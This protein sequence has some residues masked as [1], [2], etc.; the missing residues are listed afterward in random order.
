MSK[1][2]L[3][4][5]NQMIQQSSSEVALNFLLNDPSLSDSIEEDWQKAAI[6]LQDAFPDIERL[7]KLESIEK[8]WKALLVTKIQFAEFLMKD[9]RVLEM[10]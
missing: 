10:V 2:E 4:Q 3:G 9:P 1:E 5:L 6:Q 7:L 8:T